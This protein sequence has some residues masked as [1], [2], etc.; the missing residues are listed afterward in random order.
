M[1]QFVS[2]GVF[3]PS[4]SLLLVDL[5]VDATITRCGGSI[6]Y[7][8]LILEI[9]RVLRVPLRGEEHQNPRRQLREKDPKASGWR[10]A[11]LPPVKE[12]SLECIC[13]CV[14]LSLL[15][16]PLANLA[17]YQQTADSLFRIKCCNNQQKT[18][19]HVFCA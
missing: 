10:S 8:T 11:V 4:D 2:G 1:L 19:T 14:Q 12:E 17:S 5:G 16:D 3:C 6:V 13:V 7:Q 15:P 18:A 9:Q